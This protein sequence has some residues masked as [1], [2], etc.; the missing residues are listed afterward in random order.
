MVGN[1]LPESAGILQCLRMC[2]CETSL[3]RECVKATTRS[4]FIVGEKITT[5][6][7]E[8][9]KVNNKEKAEDNTVHI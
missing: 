4:G 1:K 8:K 2:D 7:K 3:K 6:D 5:D 9:A